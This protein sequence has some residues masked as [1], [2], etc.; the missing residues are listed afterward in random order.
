MQRMQ[1]QGEVGGKEQPELE[2]TLERIY[3]GFHLGE[4]A[5]S[6]SA[7]QGYMGLA[8]RAEKLVCS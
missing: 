2:L 1:S 8:G 4:L 5:P 6:A 3:E 7:Q